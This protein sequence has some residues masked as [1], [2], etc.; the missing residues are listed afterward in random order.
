MR[1]TFLPLVLCVHGCHQPSSRSCRRWPTVLHSTI[2][3]GK[4]RVRC[5][6]I[7]VDGPPCSIHCK[8]Q[9]Q[10]AYM[11]IFAHGVHVRVFF[12]NEYSVALLQHDSPRK[13]TVSSDH[14][15]ELTRSCAVVFDEN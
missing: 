10:T 9:S 12:L 11:G 2:W 13:N 7:S 3:S 4:Y 1:Y 14:C 6:R 15:V 8:L 5:R